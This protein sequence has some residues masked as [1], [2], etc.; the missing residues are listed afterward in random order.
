MILSTF[1]VACNA[2]CTKAISYCM[3]LEPSGAAA[4]YKPSRQWC[5]MNARGGLGQSC[6]NKYVALN[7]GGCRKCLKSLAGKVS[8]NMQK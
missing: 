7:V 2:D 8:A 4:H 1:A 5:D 3:E 6:C